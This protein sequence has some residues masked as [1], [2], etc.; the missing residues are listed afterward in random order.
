LTRYAPPG[1][2][3]DERMQILQFVGDTGGISGPTPGPQHNLL[4]MVGDC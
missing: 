4:K 3:V 1:V 2:L